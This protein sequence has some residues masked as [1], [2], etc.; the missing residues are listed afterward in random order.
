MSVIGAPTNLIRTPEDLR[1]AR[2]KYTDEEIA[3]DLR[4]SDF[5]KEVLKTDS[6]ALIESF[7]EC[8]SKDLF[9][10]A[11]TWTYSPKPIL[12]THILLKTFL[13]HVN[14]A[15][16]P[17]ALLPAIEN[18]PSERAWAS[19]IGL[20]HGF[21]K[22]F[23][24]SR[25]FRTRIIDAWPGI[26]KWCRYFYT[27]RISPVEDAQTAVENIETICNLIEHFCGDAA[28]CAVIRSTT[29]IITLCTQLWIHPA[30]PPL[31][32]KLMQTL[33]LQ[34]TWEDLSEV[35]DVS[36]DKPELIAKIAVD[37][38]RAAMEVSPMRPW[39]VS[40]IT[41]AIFVLS[42]LPTHCL[43]FA[44]L[45]EHG[46][47]VV[48]RM[49]VLVSQAVGSSM[50]P[51][52]GYIDC[53]NAGLTFLRFALVR[54]QSPRWVGQAVDAG[55]LGV[56]CKLS[57]LIEKTMDRQKHYIQHIVRDTLPKHLVYLSVLRAVDR[58]LKDIDSDV[59][60]S[61][62]MNT[63][64]RDDWLALM[65]VKSMRSAV[66]KLPKEVKASARVPCESTACSKY[67]SKKELMRCTGCLYV[68]YCSKKCQK[69]AWPNHRAICKLKN[70]HNK[71][72][73]SNLMFSPADVKFFRE[74]FGSDANL[75]MPHLKKVAQ[76]KFPNEKG[77][78]F[79][80][81][82]DYTNL[83]YPLGTCSLKNI[84]TYEFP[85]PTALEAGSADVA[86]Y[87]AEMINMVRRNP[88]QYTFI[89]ASFAYAEER[90]TRNFMLCPNMWD[91]ALSKE[92]H[93]DFM[94]KSCENE[95]GPDVSGLLER[96]LGL[97]F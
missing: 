58:E 8:K 93:P 87:N 18:D 36:S 2:A 10:M 69:D 14:G 89:E 21:V 49:L 68:Y 78:N 28:L 72:D 9:I 44:I 24:D 94:K 32:S 39:H 60:D 55:L 27:Q 61:T 83:E 81:C 75:H 40:T 46:A 7:K 76:R 11:H 73:Q 1:K 56:I 19:F 25:D 77:E 41:Y 48:T 51:D 45:A 23:P 85:P 54:D 6:G 79:V 62:V 37:R 92:V 20:K 86:N 84:K 31:S 95:D 71:H 4:S 43:T 3:H 33:M 13:F 80:I 70:D 67:G 52:Y 29:G 91:R 57:P 22:E 53:L 82:L 64:L 97:N 35:V 59:V 96:F 38:L 74:L 66:A 42:R 90:F 15:K 17:K 30:S 5:I 88:T 63:W 26:F 65:Q 16:V 47:W 34:C 50:D 12:P